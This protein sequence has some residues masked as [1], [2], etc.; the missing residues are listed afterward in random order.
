MWYVI[1]RINQ[2]RQQY[3]ISIIIKN[4]NNISSK[5]KQY[6]N[7]FGSLWTYLNLF[8][9]LRILKSYPFIIPLENLLDITVF[10]QPQIRRQQNLERGIPDQ[11]QEKELY[12]IFNIYDPSTL[13]HYH[14]KFRPA[15]NPPTPFKYQSYVIDNPLVKIID[16]TGLVVN[17][18]IVI[19]HSRVSTRRLF[20]WN[21]GQSPKQRTN[22]ITL[23]KKMLS[24]RF[25]PRQSFSQETLYTFVSATEKWQTLVFFQPTQIWFQINWKLFEKRE[26][27]FRNAQCWIKIFEDHWKIR[28]K[29]RYKFNQ[30]YLYEKYRF[31]TPKP[32]IKKIWKINMSTL[33]ILSPSP[34][35]KERWTKK[36]LWQLEIPFSSLSYCPD[37]QLNSCPYSYKKGQKD[38]PFRNITY[39][40]RLTQSPSTIDFPNEQFQSSYYLDDIS[41][42][43]LCF[44]ERTRIFP[45]N[46]ITTCE[47][48]SHRT[49]GDYDIAEAVRRE[50]RW[51]ITSNRRYQIRYPNN[52]YYQPYRKRLPAEWRL[53]RRFHPWSASYPYTIRSFLTS[54]L[55]FRFRK[56]WERNTDFSVFTLRRGLHK[57]NLNFLTKKNRFHFFQSSHFHISHMLVL[58][59]TLYIFHI[60]HI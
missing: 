34:V 40:E 18:P 9:I 46:S 52:R 27:V 59:T 7:N 47:L 36:T 5:V 13:R 19:C 29:T 51:R 12:E 23:A 32:T 25:P 16:K 57:W 15:P 28:E 2:Y 22:Q 1:W 21:I 20:R 24:T 17:K 43:N 48:K 14:Y 6:F 31:C 42:I 11:I 4:R 56:Q 33:P 10:E 45:P 8:P 55:S 26:I 39:A 30:F 60:S 50:A 3:I 53:G 38:R 58:P 49:R 54:P 41:K 37:I 44:Q 35:L